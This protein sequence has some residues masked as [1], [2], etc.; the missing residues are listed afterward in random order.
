MGVILAPQ[1]VRMRTALP[2]ALIVLVLIGLVSYFGVGQ[3]IGAFHLSE[4]RRALRRG[5]A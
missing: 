2:L 4:F 1:E 5:Q 3:L